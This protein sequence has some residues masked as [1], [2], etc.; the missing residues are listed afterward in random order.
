MK[1]R[2]ISEKITEILVKTQFSFWVEKSDRGIT[3]SEAN[4]REQRAIDYY[5]GK[6]QKPL[7]ITPT[8]QV[9][10]R[11]IVDMQ[12]HCIMKFLLELE[13]AGEITLAK[14]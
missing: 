1:L 13:E 9:Q 10:F 6:T 8:E 11:A 5:L 2:R 12:R 4:T 3:A 7:G 14:E